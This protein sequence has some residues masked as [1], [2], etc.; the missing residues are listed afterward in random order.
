MVMHVLQM[1]ML[2][3]LKYA[4]MDN[5]MLVSNVIISPLVALLTVQQLRATSARL[6][7]NVGSNAEMRNLM[8][9]NNA[10]MEINRDAFNVKLYLLTNALIPIKNPQ[11]VSTVEIR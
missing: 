3:V 1:D 8:M 6:Q 9:V 10:I 5:W 7:M 11:F 4:E 2:I